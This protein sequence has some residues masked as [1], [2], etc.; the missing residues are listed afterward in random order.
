MISTWKQQAIAG[1]AATYS[2]S[3]EAS[4]AAREADLEKPHAKIGPLVGRPAR[5]PG[6]CKAQDGSR[7]LR[8]QRQAAL[9]AAEPNARTSAPY[10][11]AEARGAVPFRR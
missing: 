6:R 1:I 7:T 8:L 5:Q 2:G 4:K 11:C 10:P 3:A 9:V